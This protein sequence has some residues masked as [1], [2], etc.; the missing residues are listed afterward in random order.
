M[1][2][3][4][5]TNLNIIID[6]DPGTDDALV[7]GV[8]SAFFKDNIRALISSYGNVDG[9]QTYN[10]LINLADILKIDCDFIKGSLNPMGKDNFIPTDYHGKNGLCGLM[11]PD[12]NPCKRRAEGGVPCTENLYEMIKEYKNIKYIAIGPL[13]NFAKLIDK[14]PDSVNYI[15]ELI[16]M[17]GGFEVSNMDNN[18]EYNF[19][20]DAEAVKKVLACHVK[21]V[22]ASLD[23]THRLAF[24][25]PDI[26]DITGVKRELLPDD[27]SDP[28]TVLA[29]L[30]YLNYDTS[31]K[32]GNPGAIIHDATTLAYLVG[33]DDPGAPCNIKQ[34]K[35]I[36]DEYGA[37]SKHPNGHDVTVIEEI[38]RDF[39]KDLLKRSFYEHK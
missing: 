31:V 38:D 10:N 16:I 39:V 26:E 7:L 13:T 5:I 29:K 12:A 17:G 4:E 30:F 20:M 18:T 32:N 9:D 6:T 3:I 22:L 24:S 19:S 21:K 8:A 25:L 36:S 34:Y 27:M 33:R 2:V 28:F 35:I 23:M 11:L 1:A 15:D 14:Y 37:L